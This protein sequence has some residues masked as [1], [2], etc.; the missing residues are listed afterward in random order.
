M[1]SLAL[2]A[3]PGMVRRM[4]HRRSAGGEDM[5]SGFPEV[6][7]VQGVRSRD[8][9]PLHVAYCGEAEPAVF[10]VHGWTCN[11][12]IFRYQRAH[13]CRE[14]RVVTVDLRGHGGSSRPESRDFHA[15]RLAEDLKAAVDA[16]DPGEF[17]VAGHSMG[18]FTAFKF[19]EHFGED[20]R[21]RLKGLA[22]IDSTGTDLVEGLV[23]G[24]LIDLLYPRP[25]ESLLELGGRESPLAEK[26]RAWLRGSSAAYLLVRWAAFGENP[27]AGEVEFVREMAFSTPVT[28]VSLAARGCLDYHVDYHLP[29]VD[30]PVLLLVGSRDKLTSERVNRRTC[31]LLPQARLVVF[32]GA[33]HCVQLERRAEF[34]VELEDF[35]AQ[36]FGR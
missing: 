32:K 21:G 35:L 31:A 20:Y 11:G 1:A 6:R 13:F 24:K 2:L 18:G 27:P 25:L 29:R 30:L 12:D 9:T 26:A 19:H 15:D 28:V 4:D 33:G 17:V 36:C 22:I 8:G 7:T 16:C 10:F 3:A 14:Y 5:P 23:M 34:N